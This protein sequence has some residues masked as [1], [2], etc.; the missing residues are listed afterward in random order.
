MFRSLIPNHTYLWFS[1]PLPSQKLQNHVGFL[2]FSLFLLIFLG[3]HLL[4]IISFC[5]PANQR[6]PAAAVFGKLRRFFVLQ[7]TLIPN[8]DFLTFLSLL[9]VLFRPSHHSGWFPAGFRDGELI[10]DRRECTANLGELLFWFPIHFPL[11]LGE[12]REDSI[13][14]SG[15]GLL[16][17]KS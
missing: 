12:L 14:V 8:F 7:N 13:L 2:C 6:R 9:V 17:G 4:S 3:F 1:L 15:F 11:I 5:F 10:L 16:I